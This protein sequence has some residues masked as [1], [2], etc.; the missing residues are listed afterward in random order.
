MAATIV[1]CG[2]T[3]LSIAPSSSAQ[4]R[5]GSQSGGYG[6]PSN[7]SGEVVDIQRQLADLGY[8]NGEITGQYG[9]ETQA[10]V[11][12]FQQDR[13][14]AVDGIVGPNTAQVLFGAGS[15]GQP[16]SQPY[17]SG[18]AE[19]ANYPDARNTV[20]LNDTGDQ[21]IELQRRL[22]DLGFY[23]GEI[24]GTYDYATEAAVMQFQQANGL[25]ADGV[26][27]ANTE[28]T[29]RRPT[30]EISRPTATPGTSTQN[31]DQSYNSSYDSSPNTN[32]LIQIGDTGQ[33]ISDLQLRLKELGFYQGE[34]TGVYGP[35]TEAAVTTFQQSRGLV[36]DGIVGPQVNSALYSYASSTSTSDSAAAS[37]TAPAASSTTPDTT[38]SPAVEPSAETGTTTSPNTSTPGATTTNPAPQTPQELEQARQE[39]EQARL[40]AEQA[41]LEAE[42][43]RLVLSQNFDEGP[44]S[45]VSLQRH[46]R[47]QG[48]YTGE[49]NGIFNAETQ[50]AI[51]EAQQNHELNP[52]DLTVPGTSTF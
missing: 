50:Q 11:S 47:N 9:P 31:S 16:Y 6:L 1:L 5:P 40:E 24:S 48:F 20:Q 12:R 21:V 17:D 3:S 34:I 44:Y 23:N 13:G 30:E 39:A 14:L 19:P 37:T 38:V 36:A 25:F 18:Y 29:L 8:Y 42:Q 51:I 32:G 27:G 52:E 46:L 7:N 33:T 43:A 4:V 49:L 15:S 45:V 28:A 41:R 22:A 26:V 35:E 10:A 2:A